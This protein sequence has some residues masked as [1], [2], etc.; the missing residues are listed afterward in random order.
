M[1]RARLQRDGKNGKSYDN[2]YYGVTCGVL[3][4]F[5]DVRGGIGKGKQG[6]NRVVSARCAP[7]RRFCQK[8]EFYFWGKITALMVRIIAISYAFEREQEEKGWGSAAWRR[9][10]VESAGEDRVRLGLKYCFK[11]WGAAIDVMGIA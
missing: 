10:L 6:R 2:S 1:L 5:G 4:P 8:A 11:Y 9:R 3:T 7:G